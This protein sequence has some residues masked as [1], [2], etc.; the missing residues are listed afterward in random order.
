MDETLLLSNIDDIK[1]EIEI[2][3]K[4]KIVISGTSDGGLYTIKCGSPYIFN[5][6]LFIVDINNLKYNHNNTLQY[7]KKWNDM[8]HELR[9]AECN[10]IGNKHNVSYRCDYDY[11]IIFSDY[12]PIMIKMM[13]NNS[14]YYYKVKNTL[15]HPYKKCPPVKVYNNIGGVIGLYC[16]YGE[17]YNQNQINID[18][19]VNKIININNNERIDYFIEKVFID[20]FISLSIHYNCQKYYYYNYANL[21]SPH[22]KRF[23]DSEPKILSIWNIR[24]QFTYKCNK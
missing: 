5:N 3:E 17:Y 14:V 22:F 18:L 4:N 8:S 24:K 7:C 12:Y 11:N 21:Y 1:S 2:M 13:E 16:G 19:G 15:D 20:K 9:K 6:M 23:L 10:N